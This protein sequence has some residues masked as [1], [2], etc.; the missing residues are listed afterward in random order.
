[1]TRDRDS[2]RAK[3][4]RA[5]RHVHTEDAGTDLEKIRKWTIS[6]LSLYAIYNRYSEGSQNLT[7]FLR[8]DTTSLRPGR[9]MTVPWDYT[10]LSREH[11][12]KHRVLQHMAYHIHNLV[13]HIVISDGNMFYA[14]EAAIHSWQ[15]CY[16]YVDLVRYCV[17]K[18]AAEQVKAAFKIEG[19][20][21]KKPRRATKVTERQ[22]AG[23]LAHNRKRDAHLVDSRWE[24]YK[25]IGRKRELDL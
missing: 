8:R 12:A 22:L 19:V 14:P 24:R 25:Q 6:R 17:G 10:Q 2:Q 4:Y 13:A 21:W 23:L 1:M 20:K 3:F 7:H 18:E 15:Y 9:S 11:Y 16:I 5:L